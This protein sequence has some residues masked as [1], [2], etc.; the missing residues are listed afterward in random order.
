VRGIK[1]LKHDAP[2]YMKSRI[3]HGMVT[4]P[5]S[6]MVKDI[7]GVN[8]IMWGSDYPHGR[9]IG[10]EVHE[11]LPKIFQGVPQAEQER[12]VGAN[13]AHVYGI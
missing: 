1:P 8:Q 3:W 12:M 9:S 2:E 4:D 5:Y 7:V 10:T 11:V 6:A 13:V